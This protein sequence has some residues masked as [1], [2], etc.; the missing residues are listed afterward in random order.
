MPP[1]LVIQ[2]VTSWNPN[3]LNNVPEAYDKTTVTAG[4][5]DPEWVKSLNADETDVNGGWNR[6]GANE[7]EFLDVTVRA[8]HLRSS[9][10]A[11]GR[12]PLVGQRVRI[13]GCR[14]EGGMAR[15]PARIV[16]VDPKHPV[17]G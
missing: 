17:T 15:E 3:T 4:D 13:A 16:D 7:C 1:R 10:A 12:D 14:V 5:A 6:Y 2:G 9:G 11:A 8:I